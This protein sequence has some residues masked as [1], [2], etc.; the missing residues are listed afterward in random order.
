LVSSWAFFAVF[1][2]EN[3]TFM[4]T[5]SITNIRSPFT[6]ILSC[7]HFFTPDD[8]VII[9]MHL[10]LSPSSVKNGQIPWFP[11]GYCCHKLYCIIECAH[12]YTCRH[13]DSPMY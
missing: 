4:A 3:R 8:T 2:F 1:D 5:I 10:S 6:C 13:S 11:N 9:E 12:C 7:S